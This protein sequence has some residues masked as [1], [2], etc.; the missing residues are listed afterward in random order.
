MNQPNQAPTPEFKDAHPSLLR[1]ALAGYLGVMNRGARNGYAALQNGYYHGR[2]EGVATSP[3]TPDY[4]VG[5]VATTQG[6][7][8]GYEAAQEVAPTPQAPPAEI[9]DIET[10]R[11]QREAQSSTVQ[12]EA[13]TTVD[14]EA[15]P[16]AVTNIEDL[17]EQRLSA[18]RAQV[19]A[20][21]EATPPVSTT[22]SEGYAHAA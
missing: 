18:A 22:S 2:P 6:I 20:A 16:A 3:S 5:Q 7:T 10:L 19:G 13:L 9:I 12:R 8:P 14:A 15:Q 11:A 4:H 1:G 17:Y 21:Y